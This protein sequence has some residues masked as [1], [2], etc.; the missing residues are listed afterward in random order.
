MNKRQLLK[1]VAYYKRQYK[2]KLSDVYIDNKIFFNSLFNFNQ[3]NHT[4]YIHVS[5][6]HVRTINEDIKKRSKR[7]NYQ[8]LLVFTVLHEL[9]HAILYKVLT[10]SINSQDK[11]IEQCQ[12]LVDKRFFAFFSSEATPFSIDIFPR[13]IL[14]IVGINSFSRNSRHPFTG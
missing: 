12:F 4:C 14:S 1:I 11:F 13:R 5:G 6:P 9:K 8:D 7:K 2:I 3:F 10:F